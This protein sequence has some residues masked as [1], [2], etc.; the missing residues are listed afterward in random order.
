M[1]L[2]TKR[3]AVIAVVA[4]LATSGIGAA[5]VAWDTE[6]TNTTT[7]SDVSSGTTSETVYHGDA[8]NA[9]WF[10]V[11]V[12][13]SS[14]NYTL[15]IRT[16]DDL[17]YVLYENDSAEVT[18]A[19]NNHI[20]WNVSHDELEDLPRDVDGTDVNVT[21]V[22]ES[23]SGNPVAL[24]ETLTLASGNDNATAVMH[25]TDDAGEPAAAA[26]N[27]FADT[28]EYSEKFAYFGAAQFWTDNGTDVSAW[29]G[30]TTID[31]NNSGV[32]V[33]ME[34]S[35]AASSYDAV[36]E[37]ADEGDW[38]A[39]STLFLNGK[40]VQVYAE[41]AP[42]DVGDD[43]DYAVYNEE[44]DSLDVT[45]QSEELSD[46]NTLYVR[47]GAGDGYGF[48]SAADAFGFGTAASAVSPV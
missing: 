33:H 36:A 3:L 30:W 29:S 20:A 24:S 48:W 45:I 18:D 12:D 1:K 14:L 4:M 44:T 46:V 11:T 2:N 41:S 21:I 27:L 22:N 7:T 10:E 25:L 38:M 5:A 40:P 9:T 43:Q 23:A 39:K 26:T 35:T 42:D 19:T 32:E 6:S 47:G 8:S 28:S 15:E 31:G 37:D 17:E 16:D 34:N 13:D